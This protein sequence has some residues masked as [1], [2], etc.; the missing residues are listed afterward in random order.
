M[1]KEDTKVLKG[2]AVPV[3]ICT[4][5]VVSIAVLGRIMTGRKT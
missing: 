5:V 4:V 3:I 1:S 2:L